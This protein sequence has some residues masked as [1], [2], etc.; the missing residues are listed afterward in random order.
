MGKRKRNQKENNQRKRARTVREN[1][2]H[3]LQLTP[4]EIFS[5]PERILGQISSLN[6]ASN[7][8]QKNWWEMLL[9]QG[10]AGTEISILLIIM[11]AS[12]LLTTPSV[13]EKFHRE[14][15][16]FASNLMETEHT[17]HAVSLMTLL[18]VESTRDPKVQQIITKAH[19]RPTVDFCLAH[20]SSDP[21]SFRSCLVKLLS[22]F[23][24]SCRPQ[25]ENILSTLTKHALTISPQDLGSAIVHLAFRPHERQILM[26]AALD[27]VSKLLK[28]YLPTELIG[29]IIFNGELYSKEHP[30]SA[31][32]MKFMNEIGLG[33]ITQEVRDSATFQPYLVKY[34]DIYMAI[35]IECI[36]M[37]CA[38]L[39]IP[40]QDLG[41]FFG[42]LGEIPFTQESLSLQYSSSRVSSKV[43][44]DMFLALF[45]STCNLAASLSTHCRERILHLISPIHSL[46][47]QAFEFQ[48]ISKDT[49]FRQSL[50]ISL[51]SLVK[52]L[53]AHAVL[54]FKDLIIE[55]IECDFSLIVNL[56]PVKQKATKKKK[57]Q[58]NA[59]RLAFQ[60][61]EKV[62][63]VNLAL[64]LT[65]S[66]YEGPAV[67]FNR[68]YHKRLEIAVMSLMAK[69][70][71]EP[72]RLFVFIEV[73][74]YSAI[75]SYVS[76]SGTAMR[77]ATIPY[78][79]MFLTRGLSSENSEIALSSQRGLAQIH[80]GDP[81]VPIPLPLNQDM[82][83]EIEEAF[84][85]KL[86]LE[87]GKDFIAPQNAVTTIPVQSED[88]IMEESVSETILPPTILPS[89]SDQSELKDKIATFSIPP[90]KKKSSVSQ[91]EK[92][93]PKKRK[94]E[95]EQFTS[96]K[97][98]SNL[99]FGDVD[100]ED[101]L[102]FLQSLGLELRTAEVLE[103][104]V[105]PLFQYH[106][107]TL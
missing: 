78:C 13:L 29:H 21:D 24:A 39:I 98:S 101:P 70:L 11:E 19:L 33:E 16:K 105:K 103:G 37:P 32:W 83:A 38:E 99:S 15:V 100:G 26:S 45:Q 64:Q 57:K 67:V 58:N 60:D 65:T 7:E 81:F 75:S 93:S 68:A 79:K 97:V 95:S 20:F 91:K 74:L 56:E 2:F 31:M 87:T 10:S 88:S 77:V 72:H 69:I 41:N 73:H 28:N 5:F 59:V 48:S 14:V 89:P 96:G 25:R 53:G 66:L 42:Q 43:M 46:F 40:L 85:P 82:Q 22:H 92:P 51:T 47:Q 107:D 80:R 35:L 4:T 86:S 61:V 76:F 84:T 30:E 54:F 6:F 52:T 9:K 27:K 50:Y 36:N 62:N 55:N 18:C 1:S 63:L 23:G 3:L 71:K 106:T 17:K 102:Q 8:Q 90:P 49:P 44:Q 104:D 34:L 94:R 12:L